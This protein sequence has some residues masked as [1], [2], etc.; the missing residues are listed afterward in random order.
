MVYYLRELAFVDFVYG[1]SAA[2]A[3]ILFAIILSLTLLQFR[4][5]RR[6]VHYE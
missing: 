6:W 4:I 2:V 5:Q 1:S 3:V